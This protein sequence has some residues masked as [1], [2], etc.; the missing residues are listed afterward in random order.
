[1]TKFR[2]EEEKLV[3]RARDHGEKLIKELQGELFQFLKSEPFASLLAEMTANED[4]W[5]HRA[6]KFVTIREP[7]DISSV[8]DVFVKKHV[9]NTV[10]EYVKRVRKQSGSVQEGLLILSSNCFFLFYTSL[11]C[12]LSEMLVTPKLWITSP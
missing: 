11:L 5:P 8:Y 6:F 7:I 2:H 10:S 4:A 3:K 1:M 9:V 12:R